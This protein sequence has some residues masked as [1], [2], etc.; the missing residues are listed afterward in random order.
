MA[1]QDAGLME[2]WI[3]DRINIDVVAPAATAQDV[4][5]MENWIADRIF[6]ISYAEADAAAP[7]GVDPVALVVQIPR[8]LEI[9]PSRDFI[10]R[11]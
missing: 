9:A 11:Y 6:M 4:G 10:V 5:K 1:Y 7:G 3:A 2:N 8:T